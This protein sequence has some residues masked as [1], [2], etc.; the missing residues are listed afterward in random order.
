MVWE[1][2]F[3]A[4]IVTAVADNAASTTTAATNCWVQLHGIMSFISEEEEDV[5]LSEV[6][7]FLLE[8]DWDE[9]DD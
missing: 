2:P 6:R 7:E 9:Q 3:V 8:L 1:V 4:S 5:S